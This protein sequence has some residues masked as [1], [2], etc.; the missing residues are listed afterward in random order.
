MVALVGVGRVRG[1]NK[2]QTSSGNYWPLV[3]ARERCP[4][5][6]KAAWRR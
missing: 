1:F 4:S 2:V 6:P 3:T 5:K